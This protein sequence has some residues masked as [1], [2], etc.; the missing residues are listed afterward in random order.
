MEDSI[1][2]K[3]ASQE[4]SKQQFT[5]SSGCF[6]AAA[7]NRTMDGVILELL[8]GSSRSGDPTAKVER[9]QLRVTPHWECP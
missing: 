6:R 2:T 7:R 8:V 4:S 1:C 3:V 9:G 5:A